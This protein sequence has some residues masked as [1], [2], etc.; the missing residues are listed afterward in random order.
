MNGKIDGQA[1][2]ETDKDTHRYIR[3]ARPTCFSTGLLTLLLSFEAIL[4]AATA[5][6]PEACAALAECFVV[7][8]ENKL[9][10][11]AFLFGELTDFHSC[12]GRCEGGENRQANEYV[13][14]M[15]RKPGLSRLA[16]AYA[17]CT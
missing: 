16:K 1:I 12:Q 14:D 8:L 5:S 9:C 7:P 2:A 13:S 11:C 10:A 17:L 6:V 15:V 4:V 3:L